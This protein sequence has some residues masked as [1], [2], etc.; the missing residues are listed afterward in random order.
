MDTI[1]DRG[2][3]NDLFSSQNKSN[4]QHANQSSIDCI[5]NAWDPGIPS[6]NEAN[7]SYAAMF[8]T[9]SAQI[10][11]TTKPDLSQSTPTNMYLSSS[12]GTSS[13]VTSVLLIE[14]Q[15]A[16]SLWQSSANN[17]QVLPLS[18]MVL[19]GI[20]GNVLVCMAVATEKKLQNVTN[21]F[22]TSLAVADLF[23][24]CVVMPLSIMTEFMGKPLNFN[25]IR[26][27]FEPI[28]V[29]LKVLLLRFPLHK[30]KIVF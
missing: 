26:I 7:D 19:A 22:L 9:G 18:L 12:N 27:S 29:L 16:P 21:Y 17:W 15:S 24:C 20:M 23:V 1:V 25:F 30:T 11:P 3:L 6:E 13:L 2:E 8:T 10:S 4:C 28:Y 5:Y 14:S